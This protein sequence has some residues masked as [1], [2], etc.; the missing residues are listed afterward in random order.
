MDK[1]VS[2]IINSIYIDRHIVIIIVL[3]N[4]LYFIF[5]YRYM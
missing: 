2:V 5:L 1:D 4:Y 3:N